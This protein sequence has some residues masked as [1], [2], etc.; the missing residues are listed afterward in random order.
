MR[1][2]VIVDRIEGDKAILDVH[3]FDSRIIYPACLIPRGV[4]EGDILTLD[5]KKSRQTKTMTQV[6]QKKAKNLLDRLIEKSAKSFKL[7]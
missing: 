6:R 5:L 4:K 2:K 7:S 1:A 3:G